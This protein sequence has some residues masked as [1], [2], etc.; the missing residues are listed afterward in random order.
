MF[1]GLILGVERLLARFAFPSLIPA[2]TDPSS[3][4]AF[5]TLAVPVLASFLGFYLATVGIV[6]GNSYSKASAGVRRLLLIDEGLKRHLWWLGVAIGYGLVLVLLRSLGVT[7]GYMTLI[8]YALVVALGGWAFM[9]LAFGAF[10]LFDPALLSKDPLLRLSRSIDNFNSDALLGNDAL[11]N[12]WA[13]DANASIQNIAELIDLAGERKQRSRESLVCVTKFLMNAVRSYTAKKHLLSLTGG[14]FLRRLTYQRWEEASEWEIQPA[15]QTSTPLLPEEEPV[16]DWLEQQ[17]ARVA[18]AAFKV[19]IEANDGNS[20]IRITKSAADTARVLAE[21]SLIDEAL[22]FASTFHKE[23]STLRPS[24]EEVAHIWAANP[25]SIFMGLL[26]GWRKG[27]LSWPSNICETVETTKWRDTK[28]NTVQIRGPSRLRRDGQRL[29][30]QIQAEQAISGCRVT[31]DWYLRS[32]LAISGLTALGDF[33]KELPHALDQYFPNE[34]NAKD[35]PQIRA[36]AGLQALQ[37]LRKCQ[38]VID[39]LSEA[40]TGLEALVR[41]NSPTAPTEFESLRTHIQ[42]RFNESLGLLAETLRDLPMDSS[43]SSPDFSGRIFSTLVHHI[44]QA[45]AS[46]DAE[47]VKRAFPSI[48]PS[49]A[50]RF[51][52]LVATH[53]TPGWLPG[54]RVYAPIVDVLE[55]SGLA[56][57]YEALRG[58]NSAEPVRT[59]WRDWIQE[60]NPHEVRAKQVLNILDTVASSI[61][62][63]GMTRLEWIDR[64]SDQVIEAG[65]AFP[66]YPFRNEP[67]KNAPRLIRILGVSDRRDMPAVNPR[68]IF[69]AEVVAPLSGESD[70][71]LRSRHGLDAYYAETTSGPNE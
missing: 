45:V 19:C 62:L 27:V 70:S 44:E 66:R 17:A 5:P 33:A 30:D 8:A 10:N 2:G 18:S 35:A 52:H 54:P 16:T 47:L 64:L 15:L 34:S 48:L 12:R 31:P 50:S 40:K 14:W 55:L 23:C 38:L 26:V 67:A 24:S 58:D 71:Q 25:F 68:A 65:Y 20:A 61:P 57:L 6:V 11:L 21:C 3:L 43:G 41:G 28:T 22:S 13:R 56:L 36:V 7:F 42:S 1:I 9:Q 69:A 49:A 59:A 32:E 39:A 4:W 51:D 53:E 46:G 60:A 29:L 63:V 37:T